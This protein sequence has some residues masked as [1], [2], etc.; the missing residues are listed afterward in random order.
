M[1]GGLL[2]RLMLVAIVLVALAGA[3][4]ELAA[5]RRPILLGGRTV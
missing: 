3:L 2:L 1:S 5:G 4:A